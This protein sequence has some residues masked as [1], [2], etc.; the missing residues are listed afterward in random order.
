MAIK[1]THVIIGLNVGG[2]ELMLKRL[3]ISQRKRSDISHDV[4]S[5]TG[6]GVVGE[7]I[8]ALGIPVTTLEMKSVVDAPLIVASLVRLL[9]KNAPDIVQTW[10]Y[11]ADLLGGVAARLAGVKCVVWG[12]RTTQLEKG[13]KRSTLIIRRI[14]AWI[15]S[16]VPTAIV[17]AAEASKSAHVSIG[18]DPGRMVVI[19]N[20]FDLTRLRASAEQRDMIR[21]DSDIKLNEIVI[22]SIGRFSLVK[23]H[24]NFIAAAALLASKYKNVKFLLVGRDVDSQNSILMRHI[25][26]AGYSDRF[27]LMG[28]RSDIPACLKA[29]DIFCLHSATEGFPNVLGEAMAVG[30]PCVTTDVGDASLLLGG[31]GVVVT[32]RDPHALMRGMDSLL[33]IGPTQRAELGRLA[34]VRI[35][36]FTMDKVSERFSKLYISV[37]SSL[38][39]SDIYKR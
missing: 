31:C 12:V 23:D 35:K 24:M 29:M 26:A 28:E 39:I 21:C 9:K 38:V 18:Y 22:G 7:Q 8:R 15:S 37:L 17:C 19:P 11:H 2:A 4:I 34:S 27:I 30:L 32:P 14:C 36:D 20:G 33:E 5:L 16:R 10:M 3:L 6:L 25:H 13:G 1:V